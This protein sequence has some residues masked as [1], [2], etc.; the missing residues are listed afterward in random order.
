MFLIA[1]LWPALCFL[2]TGCHWQKLSPT[3][4]IFAM[5]N[6]QFNCSEGS[7]AAEYNI[8]FYVVCMQ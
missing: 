3:C 6:Y 4:I 1:S 2:P 7:E 8:P 5:R